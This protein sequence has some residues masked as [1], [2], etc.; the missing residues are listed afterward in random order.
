MRKFREISKNNR[1]FLGA[2]EIVDN[3]TNSIFTLANPALRK[4]YGY[5]DDFFLNRRT[6]KKRPKY[7]QLTFF[8]SRT[9]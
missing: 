9:W 3:E 5:Q 6:S 8:I 2:L 4:Y 1:K 7:P